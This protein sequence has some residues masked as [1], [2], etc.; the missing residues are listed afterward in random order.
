MDPSVPGQLTPSATVL[1]IIGEPFSEEE[2]AHILEEITK[3]FHSW[4]VES[5][6]ININE[7]LAQ[8]ASAASLEVED[9]N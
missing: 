4:N 8:I 5:T 2:K 1:L 7:E 3:G 9:A 6:G